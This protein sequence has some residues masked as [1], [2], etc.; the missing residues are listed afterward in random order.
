MRVFDLEVG[1]RVVFA[2]SLGDPTRAVVEIV[3][4]VEPSDPTEEYWQQNPNIFLEPAPLEELPDADV[5]IDPE[6]PPLAVFVT[7]PALLNGVRRG[8][9]GNAG[10]L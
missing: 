7:Q 6:E 9:S 5:E 1:D 10:E 8:V 3:G 2:P 4:V